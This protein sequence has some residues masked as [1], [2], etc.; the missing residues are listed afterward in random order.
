MVDYVIGFVCAENA[1]R[2]TEDYVIMFRMRAVGEGDA[3]ERHQDGAQ[4]TRV[5]S[6]CGV[7]RHRLHVRAPPWQVH[8]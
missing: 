8:L 5:G 4:P 2:S 1:I 7:R 3:G 6:H